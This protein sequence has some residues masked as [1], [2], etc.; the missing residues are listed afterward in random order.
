M[1]IQLRGTSGSGKSTIVR[2]LLDGGY[3]SHSLGDELDELMPTHLVMSRRQ[4]IGHI[5][6]KREFTKPIYILGH[7]HTPCGGCDTLGGFGNDWIYSFAEILHNN[8]YH[9]VMEGLIIAVDRR[10]SSD[11]L[12]RKVS[13]QTLE[14]NL[15]VEECVKSV[16]ERRAKKGKDGNFN[17]KSLESR[18]L[19]ISNIHKRLETEYGVK[20]FRGNREQVKNRMYQLLTESNL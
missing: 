16:I 15:S 17:R 19:T 13:Y 4:P 9:V 8:G 20:I 6:R 5:V 3:D 14:L 11:F 2:S 18:I 12:K 7:Y 1:I 10:L